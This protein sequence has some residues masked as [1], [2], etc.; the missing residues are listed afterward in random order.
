MIYKLFSTT[1]DFLVK[2]PETG[3]GYQVIAATRKN[4][5]P[6]E[7][8]I[9]YNSELILDFDSNFKS[10]RSQILTEGYSSIY[11][12]VSYLDLENIRI[13]QKNDIKETRNI[14]ESNLESKLRK[15]GGKGAKENPKIIATGED[16]FVRLSAFEN[17]KRI[18]F[19]KKC[20]KSGAYTTTLYDYAACFK[21]NDDPIDRYA[22]PN[23]D[24]VRWAFFVKPKKGEL[25]QEGIVQ[26]AFEHEGGGIEDYFEDGT[27]PDT[28]L[29]KLEYGKFEIK[30]D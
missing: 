7:R 20:L 5:Y 29:I 4:K 26:P 3:M 15:S 24:K 8:F 6:N 9:V 23:N 22:L 13:L 17:D 1:S 18:D 16:Y 30:K 25:Y 28:Y 12:K 10:Y 11:N 27:S 14:S 21:T 2:S 19:E